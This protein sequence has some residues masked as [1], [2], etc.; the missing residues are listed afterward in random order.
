MAD[1]KNLKRIV[2][3]V[4]N[5]KR[6]G[7]SCIIRDD[8]TLL[9]MNCAALAQHQLDVIRKVCPSVNVSFHATESSSTGFMIMMSVPQTRHFVLTSECFQSAA[10]IVLCMW[11]LFVFYVHSAAAR[12]GP[13]NTAHQ[14]M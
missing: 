7:I 13:W 12:D 10:S 11:S 9:I 5:P 3:D 4:L 6:T 1:I 8:T 2:E 14:N